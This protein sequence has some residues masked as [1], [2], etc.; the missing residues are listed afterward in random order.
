MYTRNH[1]DEL[2]S[3]DSEV[4]SLVLLLPLLDHD[5]P[6]PFCDEWAFVEFIEL[7]ELSSWSAAC[8]MAFTITELAPSSLSLAW[9]TSSPNL[10]NFPISMFS[11]S[12]TGSLLVTSNRPI[13]PTRESRNASKPVRASVLI[14]LRSSVLMLSISFRA[15]GNVSDPLS[16]DSLVE[17]SVVVE[18][19]IVCFW[20]FCLAF[21]TEF[22][23]NGKWTVFNEISGG[24]R[25]NV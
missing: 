8:T 3:V 9:M 14:L 24:L 23:C 13:K 15:F 18:D 2:S 4:P 19:L 16:K 11:W 1:C 25:L 6:L 7:R 21:V 5:D 22:H 12:F 10:E 20:V 17:D